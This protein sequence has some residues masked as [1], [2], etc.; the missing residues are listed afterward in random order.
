M[1]IFPKLLQKIFCQHDDLTLD[2]NFLHKK[3]CPEPRRLGSQWQRQKSIQYG[4]LEG[5]GREG[6]GSRRSHSEEVTDCHPWAIL[7]RR[8]YLWE[9]WCCF[10]CEREI[11]VLVSF[12]WLRKKKKSQA[13]QLLEGGVY[14]VLMVPEDWCPQGQAEAAGSRPGNWSWKLSAH[15]SITDRRPRENPRSGAS[16]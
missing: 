5:E 4:L 2:P 16:L 14:L 15:I 1:I 13:R 10:L 11:S 8:V 9:P 3:S 12:L 7:I 6:G